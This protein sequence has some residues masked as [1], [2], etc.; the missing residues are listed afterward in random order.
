MNTRKG[1][2]EI[3]QRGKRGMWCV[4]Y[5]D[6]RGRRKTESTGSTLKGDAEKLLRDR[7]TEKDE[8]LPSSGDTKRLRFDDAVQRVVDDYT[9]NDRKSTLHVENRIRL[10]LLPYFGGIRMQQISDTDIERFQVKRRAAGASNAEIN[11][12]LA[13]VRR[14]YRLAKLRT[15]PDIRMLKE[16]AP[17]TGF[18]ER[19]QFEA[20]RSHLPAD[21][22][23]VVT[24]AYY[25]GWRKSEIVSL[26]WRQVNLKAGTVRLDA[27]TTKNGD[28]RVVSFGKIDELKK[29]LERRKADTD[30]LVRRDNTIVRRVFHRDGVPIK[31]FRGAWDA[32]CVQAGCPG[33]LL[34]DFRRTA[35]RNLDLAGVSRRVAMQ[36][37]GHKTE[38]IYNRY[39]IVSD[40]DLQDAAARLN[41]LATGSTGSNTGSNQD[42]T[43]KPATNKSA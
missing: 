14:A 28:G 3:F 29:L 38:S 13:I 11:R 8:G 18:F 31:S 5:Y 43:D 39:R 7:L 40:A 1:T 9:L 27:G 32:A 19:D 6:H 41:A 33:K 16:S 30:A 25:T 34:H 42:R 2:G 37:V 4:R 24:F 22:A 20:V 35:C 23:D 10:H 21:I 17:R 15:R 36:M 12:E 26:E